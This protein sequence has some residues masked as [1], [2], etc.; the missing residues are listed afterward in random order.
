MTRAVGSF[1]GLAGR[2]WPGGLWVLPEHLLSPPNKTG[3]QRGGSQAPRAEPGSWVPLS[4]LNAPLHLGRGTEQ[5]VGVGGTSEGTEAQASPRT[6]GQDQA[7]APTLLSHTLRR[8]KIKPAEAVSLWITREWVW[9]PGVPHS[10]VCHHWRLIS[11]TPLAPSLKVRQHAS[12]PSC[13][14]SLFPC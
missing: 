2:P 5:G 9:G 14:F 6:P 7:P 13:N 10:L 12:A 3:E 4:F 8:L 1:P 11:T